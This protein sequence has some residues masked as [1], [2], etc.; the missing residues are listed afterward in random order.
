MKLV[1]I[2]T[3]SGP[4]ARLDAEM[5]K[6]LLEA[7]GISCILPG[8]ISAE[9]IPIFDVPVLVSEEDAEQAVAVLESYL[10]D[11]GPTPVE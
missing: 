4:T 7:E 10:Q 1:R 3:F 2:R 5:A 9:T 8:E 11:P 6:S